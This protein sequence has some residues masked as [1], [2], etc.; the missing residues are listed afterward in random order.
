MATAIQPESHPSDLSWI[1][2]LTSAGV[3]LLLLLACFLIV[4]P[5]LSAALW[6]AVLCASTWGLFQRLDRLLG[7]R[8]TLAALVMT[9]LLT[10]SI[11]APFA[12]VGFSLV[13]EIKVTA[14][15][16]KKTIESGPL[17]VPEWLDRVPLIGHPIGEHYRQLVGSEISLVDQAKQLSGPVGRMI[18]RWSKAFASGLAE[19]CLSLAIGLFLY[20]DGEQLGGRVSNLAIR[21]A[22]SERGLRLLKLAQDTCVGVVYGVVGTGIIHAVVMGLG[23][24]IA[25]VPGALVL[26]F[27]TFL[28]SALPVGPALIWL[29]A[30]IWLFSQGHTG[31]AIFL[32]VWEL[33]FNFLIDGVLR[34][35]I[36]A[37]SGGVPLLLVFIGIFGGAAAFGFLGVFLGP[38]LLAVGYSLL[39]DVTS[40]PA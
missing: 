16:V 12:I 7:D 28:L 23:L 34:P 10:V 33:I 15:V 20:R 14:S 17:T 9:L 21:I 38:A 36:I 18:I 30:G 27:V 29:P 6:A 5:F 25:G 26:A 24:V 11:V 3:A 40:A 8:R 31:W 32:V 13:D 37:E 22:G 35:I 39:D 1:E 19:L 4:K 2:R